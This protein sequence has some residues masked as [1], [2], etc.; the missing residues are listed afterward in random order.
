LFTILIDQ[1]GHP[2]ISEIGIPGLPAIGN[3]WVDD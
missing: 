2:G 1:A 3:W